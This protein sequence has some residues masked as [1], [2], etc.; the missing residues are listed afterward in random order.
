LHNN[1]VYPVFFAPCGLRAGLFAMGGEIGPI[2]I[3]FF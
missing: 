2:A 1:P 3:I